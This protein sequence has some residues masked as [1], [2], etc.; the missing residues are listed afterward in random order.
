MSSF[1]SDL[2]LFKM[3]RKRVCQIDA[4]P[5]HAERPI[6]DLWILGKAIE[7]KAAAK[8]DAKGVRRTLRKR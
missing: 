7:Y 2:A 8:R 4:N 1:P 5:A 6:H 3:F